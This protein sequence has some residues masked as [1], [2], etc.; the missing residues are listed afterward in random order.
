MAHHRLIGTSTAGLILAAGIAAGASNVEPKLADAVMNRDSAA[1][2]S[3]L[4]RHVDVN[5]PQSD[6]TTALQWSAHWD[7]LATAELLLHAGAKAGTA[8]VYGDTPLLE[9]CTNGDAALIKDLIAAGAD[10]NSARPEG[11]TALMT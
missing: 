4:T 7:D 9:A 3:L 2:R 8:N 6:G 11:Q 1:I 5:V 10:P